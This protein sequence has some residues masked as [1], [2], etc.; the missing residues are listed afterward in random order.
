MNIS[1]ENRQRY[2]WRRLGMAGFAF[3]LLKGLVWLAVPVAMY[4]M[5]AAG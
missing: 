1:T 5:G 4:L 2:F 3:F